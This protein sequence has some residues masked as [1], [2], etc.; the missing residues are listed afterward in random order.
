[1]MSN[2]R[3]N[4]S[5]LPLFKKIG[6]SLSAIVLGSPLLLTAPAE[7]LPSWLQLNNVSPTS[8]TTQSTTPRQTTT[9]QSTPNTTSTQNLNDVRFS[10]Q[11]SNGQYT[12]MYNPQSQSQ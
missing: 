4:P 12:V 11:A 5:R 8:R 10:C 3:S 1:M 9:A 2:V 6:L 7:A